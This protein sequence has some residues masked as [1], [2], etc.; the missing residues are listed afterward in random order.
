MKFK[1]RPK[2]NSQPVNWA[3]E[4]WDKEHYKVG[5]KYWVN[6]LRFNLWHMYANLVNSKILHLFILLGVCQKRLSDF[7]MRSESCLSLGVQRNEMTEGYELWGVVFDISFSSLVGL[8]KSQ[9][10]VVDLL[11]I[12]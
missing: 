4:E 9:Y 5:L 11:M 8:W 7:E 6:E 12:A 1:F 2:P 10:F 3:V